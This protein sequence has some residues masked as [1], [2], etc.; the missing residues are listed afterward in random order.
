M[1]KISFTCK[2]TLFRLIAA[3]PPAVKVRRILD[4]RR[5]DCEPSIPINEPLTKLLLITL[6]P[7]PRKLTNNLLKSSLYGGE[8]LV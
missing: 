1:I 2:Q 4:A 7:N 5:N 8:K 3:L 6:Q